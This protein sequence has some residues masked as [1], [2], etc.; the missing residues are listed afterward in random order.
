MNTQRRHKPQGLT[1]V[2]VLIAMALMGLLASAALTL[3]SYSSRLLTR[4]QARSEHNRALNRL[5]LAMG[6]RFF[7]TTHA[8]QS[9]SADGSVLNLVT[10]RNPEGA[11]QTDPQGYPRWLAWEQIAL[12]DRR[13]AVWRT[14]S[15]DFTL[16]PGIAGL[17]GRP[18]DI[19]AREVEEFTTT[20]SADHSVQMKLIWSGE[21]D[22]VPTEWTFRAGQGGML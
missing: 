22:K 21:T 20:I 4:S 12:R 10:A 18:Y 5:Y 2:E 13:L 1:L 15:N 17:S 7:H 6:E 9:V 16:P 8:Y 11:F 14:E 3:M 19:L